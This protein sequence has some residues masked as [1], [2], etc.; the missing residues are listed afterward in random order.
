MTPGRTHG[1]CLSLDLLFQDPFLS[2]AGSSIRIYFP[3]EIRSQSLYA[4]ISGDAV[5]MAE[6]PKGKSTHGICLLGSWHGSCEKGTTQRRGT[7]ISIVSSM[8]SRRET[9]ER[10]P[11]Q[12]ISHA[13]DFASDAVVYAL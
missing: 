5:D 4:G 3:P 7:S 10:T 8:R 2:H 12:K 1:T 13:H 6:K 9:S 11:H